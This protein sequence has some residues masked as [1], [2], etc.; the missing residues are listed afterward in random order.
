MRLYGPYLF[1]FFLVL[2]G[3]GIADSSGHRHVADDTGDAE[4]RVR[5]AEEVRAHMQAA[6]TQR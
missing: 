1:C 5:L 6:G 4:M 3:C 2:S